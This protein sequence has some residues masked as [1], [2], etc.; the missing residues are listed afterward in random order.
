MWNL[1]RHVDGCTAYY[2][3]LNERRWFDPATRGTNVD[4]THRGVED[5]WKEYEDL[6]VLGHYY[7]EDWIGRA[8]YMSA[9]SWDPA[10]TAYVKTLVRSARG[11]AVLQFNR[12]DFRLKW[13]RRTFPTAILVHLYRHPR[14]QWCSTLP[15]WSACSS[16]AT[17]ADFATSDHYYFSPGQRI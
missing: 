14:D 7:R 6:E 17:M 9:S 3:P 15:N 2:E 11:R 1:F 10:L 16:T 8:L 12:I 5:Y 13:F 4:R